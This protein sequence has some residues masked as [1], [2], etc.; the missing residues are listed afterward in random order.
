GRD[1]GL[2]RF[3]ENALRRDQIRDELAS[4]AAMRDLSLQDLLADPEGLVDRLRAENVARSQRVAEF[5]DAVRRTHS[6]PELGEPVGEL[7]N[8][9]VVRIAGG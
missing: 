5:A 9:Q 1:Q 6:E 3:F 8:R 2:R 7:L 4:W